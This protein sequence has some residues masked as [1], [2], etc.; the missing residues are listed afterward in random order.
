MKLVPLTALS[1]GLAPTSARPTEDQ[2]D[3]SSNLRVQNARAR[4][5]KDVAGTGTYR[6]SGL[7][8]VGHKLRGLRQ[9]LEVTQRHVKPTGLKLCT[10]V[11][12][13]RVVSPESKNRA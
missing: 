7:G 3:E 9:V 10:L 12:S 11:A 4:R 6:G 2:R 8:I 1:R 5:F 13:G